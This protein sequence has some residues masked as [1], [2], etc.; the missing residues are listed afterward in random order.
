MRQIESI[1]T[2]EEQAQL[3]G[4]EEQPY[5]LVGNTLMLSL[6]QGVTTARL[7]DHEGNLITQWTSSGSYTLSPGIY[8]LRIG[9]SSYKLTL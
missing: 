3:L 5:R 2:L 1:D 9:R 6:P 7:Y 4:S 8:L